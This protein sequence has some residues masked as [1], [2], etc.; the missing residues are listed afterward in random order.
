MGLPY[1]GL[2]STVVNIIRIQKWYIYNTCII[3]GFQVLTFLD[4]DF[5]NVL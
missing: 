1:M 4:Q 3:P 2:L 5:R